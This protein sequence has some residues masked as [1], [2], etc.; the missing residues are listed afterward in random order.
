ML[1]TV[2]ILPWAISGLPGDSAAEQWSTAI[3][4]QPLAELHERETIQEIHQ[5]EPFS[6]VALTADSL[7]GTSA[8]IRAKHEDG[9][10]GP[11]YEAEAL[12]GV[13]PEDRERAGGHRSGHRRWELAQVEVAHQLG[14]MAGVAALLDQEPL[15][16][17]GRLRI[18]HRRGRDGRPVAWLHRRLRVVAEGEQIAV[19]GVASSDGARKVRQRAVLVPAAQQQ[20]G[21]ADGAG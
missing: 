18:D 11:W 3:N 6:L 5:D 19:A 12:E 10:W 16:P 21:A 14:E 20:L 4:Q 2:A 15:P 1:G 7:D 17:G 8:R 13:G 9:S